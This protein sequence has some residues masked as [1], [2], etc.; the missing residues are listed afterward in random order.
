MCFFDYL[1][2]SVRDPI[3]PAHWTL[4]SG[5]PVCLRLGDDEHH[6]SCTA[7]VCSETSP[8]AVGPQNSIITF[9]IV[10]LKYMSK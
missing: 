8:S 9:G 2:L 1:C 6:H 10:L 4:A 3:V 7:F 5:L